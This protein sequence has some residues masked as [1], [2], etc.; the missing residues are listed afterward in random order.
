MRNCDRSAMFPARI[1]LMSC[2][3]VAAVAAVAAAAGA[4]GA[5]AA[6]AAAGPPGG[7]VAAPGAVGAAA[8]PAQDYA[9]R[10][11]RTPSLGEKRLAVGSAQTD[12]RAT[13]GPRPNTPDQR[14]ISTIRYV[15]ATEILAVSAQGNAQRA[16]LTV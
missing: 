2:L 1:G 8:A 4:A 16:A 11:T 6:V 15:V 14:Q 3:F 5:A 7:V 10:L 13:G 9:L 12:D